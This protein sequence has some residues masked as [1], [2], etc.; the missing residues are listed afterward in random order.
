MKV[1]ELCLGR[2]NGTQSQFVDLCTPT[3]WSLT[4]CGGTQ[5]A[6]KQILSE[7]SGVVLNGFEGKPLMHESIYGQRVD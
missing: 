7:S 4:V 1:V 6:L 3:Q 2:R 5:E